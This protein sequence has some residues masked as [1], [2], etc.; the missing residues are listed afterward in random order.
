MKFLQVLFLSLL[1]NGNSNIYSQSM[2]EHWSKE[3]LNLI[4][5]GDREVHMRVL[6]TT[7]LTDK[8]LLKTPCKDVEH[9]DETLSLLADRMLSTVRNPQ[10]LGVGIAAPQVGVLR[11]VFWFMRMDLQETPFGLAVNPIILWKSNLL[12]KG[13]EGCLSIPDVSDSVYRHYTLEVEYFDR[14]GVK[15]REVLEGFTA[16]IFQHEFDHL[17]GILFPDR[18]A[19]QQLQEYQ[20]LNEMVDFYTT[21]LQRRN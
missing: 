14:N 16:V 6:L 17:E 1:L 21:E 19:E 2:N 12:R 18:V 8:T 9:F 3:E 4:N 20:K 5:S 11:R 7:D 15:K 13:G 10:H